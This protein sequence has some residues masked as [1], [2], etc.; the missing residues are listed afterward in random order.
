MKDNECLIVT[1]LDES[2][3]HRVL[4][5]Y[6]PLYVALSESREDSLHDKNGVITPWNAVPQ[7]TDEFPANYGTRNFIQMLNAVY[8]WALS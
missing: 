4:R 5:L 3:T 6:N 1:L 2:F 7:P 8:N